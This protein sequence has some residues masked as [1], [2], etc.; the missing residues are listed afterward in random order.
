MKKLISALSLALLAPVALAQACPDKNVLYWQAF[1]PGGGSDF[2]ARHQQVVLKKCPRS[3]LIVQYK[4]GAGG[5]LMWSQIEPL[6]G[7]RLEHRRRQLAALVFRPIEGEVRCRTANVTRCSGSTSRPM[8]WWCQRAA[9]TRPF[10][11]FRRGGRRRT[12]ARSS[13]GGSGATRPTMP[14]MSA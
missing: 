1:P 10:A 13:L 9:R 12:R 2:S 14:R 7:R 4:A 3:T 11:D 5:T 6:P 8:R